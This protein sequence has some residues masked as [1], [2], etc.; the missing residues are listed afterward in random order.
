MATRY[1]AVSAFNFSGHQAL[2][3][4]ANS[5][6]GW[7]GGLANLFAACVMS[8]PAYLLSRAW[9]WEVNGRHDVRRH[10]LPFWIITLVGLVVSTAMAAARC[11]G[12]G[13]W[14][15]RWPAPTCA[16]RRVTTRR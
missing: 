5:V 4:L 3:F 14:S 9:V 15:G 10:V 6:W 2:L 7:P 13:G 16:A 11:R 8:V 1:L 12:A